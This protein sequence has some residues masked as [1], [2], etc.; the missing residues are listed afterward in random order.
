MFHINLGDWGL[1]WNSL[2]EAVIGTTIAV[3]RD[4]RPNG[5]ACGVNVDLVIKGRRA[6]VMTSWH[7]SSRDSAPRLV[8]AYPS[9]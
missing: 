7:Y 5:I 8:T 4:H 6:A 9:P 1:L 2:A 3:V